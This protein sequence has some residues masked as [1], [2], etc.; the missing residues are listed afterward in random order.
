MTKLS[1]IENKISLIQKYLKILDK[2]KGLELKIIEKDDEKRGAIERYLYLVSQAAID[3][4]EAFIAFKTFRKPTSM[5]E[6]FYVL[7]EEKILDLDLMEKM[8]KMTG[9]RNVIAHD[10]EEVDYG[11]VKEVLDNGLD[12][13]VAFVKVIRRDLRL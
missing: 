12:D 10:Y 3:L 8:I 9:F 7:N 4:A 1:T 2:Y 6:S 13:I 11:I 5:S